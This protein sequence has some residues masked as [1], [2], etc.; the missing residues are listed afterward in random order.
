MSISH[1]LISSPDWTSATP[2]L[3]HFPDSN[4]QDESHTNALHCLKVTTKYVISGSA[5]RSIRIWDKK[6]RTLALPPLVGHSGTVV[7]LDVSKLL[8]LLFSGDSNGEVIIWDFETGDMVQRFEKAHSDTVL[9]LAFK[10]GYLVTAGR[11]KSIKVWRFRESGEFELKHL[12]LGHE[13]PVLHVQIWGDGTRAVSTSGDRTLRVWD[14]GSGECVRRI[15]GVAKAIVGFRF[16]ETGGGTCLVAA[17]TDH[18]IRI[19]NFEDG[20]KVASLEGHENVVRAVKMVESGNGQG[21]SR[22][23][24]SASYD[25]TVRV[26]EED[27]LGRWTN[28]RTHSFSEAVLTQIP[29]FSYVPAEDGFLQ[30]KQK[31]SRIS[32]MEVDEGCMYCCGEGKEIVCWDFRG[33]N[34]E[35]ESKSG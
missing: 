12:L 27:G 29:D 6:A 31:P 17:C 11:D 16:F 3:A 8:A 5:D 23:I 35:T 19:Y 22:W 1:T 13:M 18:R 25:G 26:W 32:D 33:D 28:I 15:D 34:K 10:G 20:R 14:L 4:H 30:V 2:T 24:I 9:D 7:A 21:R